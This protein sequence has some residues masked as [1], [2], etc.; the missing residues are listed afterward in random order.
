MVNVEINAIYTCHSMLQSHKVNATLINMMAQMTRKNTV[1][2][3]SF[4]SLTKRS[5]RPVYYAGHQPV[6]LSEDGGTFKRWS[7]TGRTSVIGVSLKEILGSY[8]LLSLS[9]FLDC[10]ELSVFLGFVL[11]PGCASSPRPRDNHRQRPLKL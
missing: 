4:C 8:I 9:L 1:P 5:Q 2:I 11:L 3:K 6:A 7:L 10:H